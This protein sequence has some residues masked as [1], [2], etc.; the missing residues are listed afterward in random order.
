MLFIKRIP[1]FV[2][3]DKIVELFSRFGPVLSASPCHKVEGTEQKYWGCFLQYPS[4]Q[5]ASDAVDQMNNQIISPGTMPIHVTY[6]D[7][8]RPGGS[9]YNPPAPITPPE[10]TPQDQMNLLP[11]FFFM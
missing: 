8:T 7:E 5:S 9:F 6:A 10:F 3:L 11:S 2:D 1:L 4:I